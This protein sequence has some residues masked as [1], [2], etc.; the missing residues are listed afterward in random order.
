M[1]STLTLTRFAT[2]FSNSGEH[3]ID[4][5][6]LINLLRGLEASGTMPILGL[7]N[8][9]PLVPMQGRANH[10]PYFLRGSTV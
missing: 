5:I 9:C 6:I 4:I 8:L 7:G 3:S 10:I 1:G 2:D